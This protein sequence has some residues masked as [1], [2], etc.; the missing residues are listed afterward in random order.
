M[1]LTC[2][3]A[4]IVDRQRRGGGFM[5]TP[6]RTL[7]SLAALGATLTA[8]LGL[9]PSARADAPRTA[10]DDD[11]CPAVARLT[12]IGHRGA[13]GYRPE[14]TLASYQLAIDLG[15]DFIEPDLVSTKDGH[16]IARHENDISG[17]TNVAQHPEFASRKTT[18]RIDGNPVTGWFTEDFTLAEIKTLRAIERLPALRPQ[19]ATF[20]GQFE[21]PTFEEVIELAQREGRLRHRTIGVYPETKHA[22][23]FQGIGLA[24]EEPLIRT[25][26]KFGLADKRDA[27]FI[28]S[29]EVHNLQKLRKMT[30]LPLIQLVD[31]VG[32]PFDFIVAGDKRT[33]ADLVTP[34]GLHEVARYAD[35]V[36]VNKDLIVPRDATGK[37]QAPTDL[38]PN[39]HA[40]HLLVHAWTFRAENT[41]LPL[42]FQ[43][44]NPAD[45]AFPGLRGNFPAELKLFFGLG[46]DGAFSDNSDVVVAVR[47]GLPP[48]K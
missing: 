12:A 21:V 48:C 19:N 46:L 25:L 5:H 7:R 31:E 36:G 27:V 11:S 45:P 16:L 37:L 44:G 3:A 13:A 42:D 38:I 41:F 28:Q 30:R 15:A 35:G 34:A 1:L 9:V 24:L 2:S 8:A 20:D 47:T 17:T 39:A 10:H 22:T 23:Y 33:Y 29:F 14:H 6:V 40:E 26:K 18:K 32:A 4:V 43:I